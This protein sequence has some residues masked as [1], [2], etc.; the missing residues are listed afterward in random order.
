MKT[1]LYSEINI[2]S[3]IAL[4]AV[5]LNSSIFG[6]ET[7]SK[8]RLFSCSAY[9][10]AM[11]CLLDFLWGLRIGGKL[12]IYELMP[13]LVNTLYFVCYGLSFCFW[14][15][16]TEAL[17]GNM[18]LKSKK[19]TL[20]AF[21]PLGVLIV[22]LVV[23]AFT[24]CIFSI[25]ENLNYKRGP[26][27]FTQAVLTYGYIAVAVIKII[28]N[29]ANR[30]N[31]LSKDNI[32]FAAIFACPLVVGSTLQVFLPNIPITCLGVVLAFAGVHVYS[33]NV[34]ISVDMLTGI[35]NRHEL[36]NKLEDKIS[37]LKKDERL[38]FLFIDIDSFKQINDTFGHHEGD[39]AL[40]AVAT[41][42]RDLCMA[43]KGFCAR[44]GGDEFAVVQVLK[45]GEDITTVRKNIY[46]AVEQI[47]NKNSEYSLSVSIGCAL[48]TSENKSI[49]ELIS[50]ADS[51]MYNKKM[52]RKGITKS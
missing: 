45:K 44:Y 50:Q 4:L 23:S 41:E 49:Q 30:E 9:F 16:Y 19:K 10:A 24:G 32:I 13:I 22:L 33:L 37:S 38:Y 8:N 40:K 3:I 14:F 12:F 51:N 36:M 43:N 5:A 35:S 25:D 47:E 2:F 34:H 29:A 28:Y 20:L 18:I 46:E 1:L 31:E 21:L 15:L 27:F 42:L 17:R 11:A 48:Y 26:L 52:Q 39:N 6:V 7:R